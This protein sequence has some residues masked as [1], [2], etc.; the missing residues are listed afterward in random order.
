MTSCTR[1][2]HFDPPAYVGLASSSCS[3]AW[4]KIDKGVDN[5]NIVTKYRHLRW[6]AYIIVENLYFGFDPVDLQ[7]KLW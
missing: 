4:S 2:G 6:I 7:T 3:Y 1:A 5:L